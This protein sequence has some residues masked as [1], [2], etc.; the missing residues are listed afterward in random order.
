MRAADFA[1]LVFSPDDK[2]TARGTHHATPRDN[3]I[4]ELGLFMG[5]LGRHR[6]FVVHPREGMLV[7]YA[8]PLGGIKNIIGRKRL[9]LK[10][11]S[12]LL[13]LTLLPYQHS[14]ATSLEEALVPT[15]LDVIKAVNNLGP[16]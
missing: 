15:C 12:D 14:L 2:L 4:F 10:I 5:A 11:P 13:G 6:T 9:A 8:G 7:K 1:V 16:K 3:V